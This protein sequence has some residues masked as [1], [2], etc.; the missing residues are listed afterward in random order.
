M[1]Q[2]IRHQARLNLKHHS[3]FYTKNRQD[4]N[5][6]VLICHAHLQKYNSWMKAD[7]RLGQSLKGNM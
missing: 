7:S 2:A 1:S 6:G 4:N 5:T 3:K